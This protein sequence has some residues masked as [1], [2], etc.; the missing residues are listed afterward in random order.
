VSVG[1]IKDLLVG[2]SILIGSLSSAFVLIWN[3]IR[4]ARRGGNKQ[5]AR[6]AS[7]ETAIKLL[8]AVRDGDIT[9]EEIDDIQ[10]SLRKEE[11]L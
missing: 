11:E 6:K 4:P 7:K 8:E 3:T 2:V 5:V 1:D 9:P 10:A